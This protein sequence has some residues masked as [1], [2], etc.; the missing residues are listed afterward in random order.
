MPS[1]ILS[2][3]IILSLL[4]RQRVVSAVNPLRF[5]VRFY[6]HRP[7]PDENRNS[8]NETCR[9]RANATKASFLYWL[10]R[11]VAWNL[12]LFRNGLCRTNTHS[13]KQA[14]RRNVQR[15]IVH[16]AIRDFVAKFTASVYSHYI[17][18]VCVCVCVYMCPAFFR[19]WIFFV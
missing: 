18:Y 16:D 6:L 1:V 19:V 12:T 4:R 8:T 15:V 9:C 13:R 2:V 14:E 7:I 3:R 5:V 11:V 10:T 17:C